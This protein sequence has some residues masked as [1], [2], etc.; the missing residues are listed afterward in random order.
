M[1]Y[2]RSITIKASEPARLAD[3][4]RAVFELKTVSEESSFI[5]LSDRL[6][7]LALLKEN[8]QALTG[9]HA[10]GFEVE[11]VESAKQKAEKG[12]PASPHSEFQVMDPDKT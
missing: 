9:M 3:F 2:L 10:S 12:G 8:N 4:Y 7:T 1:A 6:F 5:P 11:S